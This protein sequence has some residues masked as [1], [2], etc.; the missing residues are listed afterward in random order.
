MRSAT[1]QDH[2]LRSATVQANPK[3]S[4]DIDES[5]TD[6]IVD[7]DSAMLNI[8]NHQEF[9]INKFLSDSRN[10]RDASIER[11]REKAYQSSIS[12]LQDKIKQSSKQLPNVPSM[13]NSFEQTVQYVQEK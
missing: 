6:N 1:T 7:E 3:R 12:V 8:H 13:W 9:A 2:Q 10:A 4:A 11:S 5:Q